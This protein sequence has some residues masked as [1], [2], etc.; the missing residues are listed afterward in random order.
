MSE[1][2]PPEWNIRG[3]L[4]LLLDDMACWKCSA[5][6]RV[7]ALA[8][9]ADTEAWQE[10]AEPPRWLP[11]E[12]PTTVTRVTAMSPNIEAAVIGHLS[13]LRPTFSQTADMGYWMNHCTQC[14]AGTGDFY[15]H[16]PDGPFFAWPRAGREGIRVI[17][18]GV[19]ELDAEPPYLSPP[20]SRTRRGTRK[21]TTNGDS[22]QGT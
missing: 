8:G 16:A 17:E 4:L 15:T 21:K 13:T 18:L 5:T 7:G 20:E 2:A 12:E 9:Q 6:I 11:F 3:T 14:G 10:D 22:P 1:A 19:G